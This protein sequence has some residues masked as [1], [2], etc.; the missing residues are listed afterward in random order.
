MKKVAMHITYKVFLTRIIKESYTSMRKSQRTSVKLDKGFKQANNER[1]NSDRSDMVHGCIFIVLY[2]VS[3][4]LIT[5]N[6]VIR[7]LK[8]LAVWNI[9]LFNID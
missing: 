1:E 8:R 4:I 9:K 6:Y 5:F 7:I 3:D 2:I